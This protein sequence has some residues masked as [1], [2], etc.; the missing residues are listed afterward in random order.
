MTVHVSTEEQFV[1]WGNW[2]LFWQKK[3]GR[4][5]GGHSDRHGGYNA[6]EAFLGAPPFARPNHVM[7]GTD[8]YVV[9]EEAARKIKMLCSPHWETILMAYCALKGINDD[10]NQPGQI[11]SGY[12]DL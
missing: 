8:G 11:Q 12:A 10:G 3:L 2:W 7:L 9:E 4:K 5:Y 1:A 6:Y